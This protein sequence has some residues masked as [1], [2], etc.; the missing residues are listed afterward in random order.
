MFR[1]ALFV[2]FVALGASAQ[3]ESTAPPNFHDTTIRTRVTNGLSMPMIK[4]LRLKGAR[5]RTEDIPD[6]ANVHVTSGF[7]RITQCDEHAH[8][9]LFGQQKSFRKDN[10]RVSSQPG[11]FVA[12]AI[13]PKTAPQVT[14]THNSVDTGETKTLGGYTAHHIKTTITVDPSNG[15]A[16]KKGKTKIDGWYLDIAGWRCDQPA[17]WPPFSIAG[18][19]R[20]M[21]A[22]G[23]DRFVFKYEGDTPLGYPVEESS[24]E[25]SAGNVIVNKTELVEISEAPLDDSLFD[26][27]PDYTPAPEPVHIGLTGVSASPPRP[28]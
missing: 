21:S 28:Q 15:A 6:S 25:K 20:P 24:T 16:T 13:G 2:L 5:E 7:A 22:G 19:H 23:R 10:F 3:Q 1:L 12:R 18:W 17:S 4:T 26:V 27:P 14:V 9:T 8:I 11:T